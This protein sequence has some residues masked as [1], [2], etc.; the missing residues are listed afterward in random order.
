ML[1]NS[2]TFADHLEQ[3]RLI[4]PADAAEQGVEGF[5]WAL[6]VELQAMQAARE[7]EEMAVDVP[8]GFP[9]AAG[10]DERAVG[11][12]NHPRQ[13]F[14]QRRGVFPR[15]GEGSFLGGREEI[16]MKLI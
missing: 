10:D 1:F 11:L 6:A 14:E 7:V 9:D 2:N 16:H 15:T 8:T 13:L 3:Q 5:L 12:K 4:R